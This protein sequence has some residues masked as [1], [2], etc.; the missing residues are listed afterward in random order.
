MKNFL[1]IRF[2]ALVISLVILLLVIFFYFSYPLILHSEMN[3]NI[4]PD[5][6][7]SST[8][9]LYRQYG[10]VEYLEDSEPEFSRIGDEFSITWDH[11]R[12][13]MNG[14]SD[15][16]YWMQLS[17]FLGFELK[18]HYNLASTGASASYGYHK[19]YWKYVYNNAKVYDTYITSIIDR[20][21]MTSISGVV[22]FDISSLPFMDPKYTEDEIYD[23]YLKY[24]HIDP[25]KQGSI[26]YG[27]FIDR[28]YESPVDNNYLYYV[29]GSYYPNL[30]IYRY[31]RV[32]AQV[33]RYITECTDIIDNYW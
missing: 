27:L 16:E 13:L 23:L 6:V 21:M 7:E 24:N 9:S 5:L 3:S 33:P 15:D 18:P 2:I 30:K 19:E 25:D 11:T 29:F 14:R 31:F 22:D 8:N 12:L 20:G 32:D 28:S 26:S 10:I 4:N 17:N 1:S